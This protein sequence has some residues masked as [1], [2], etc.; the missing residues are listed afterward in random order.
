MGGG[1]PEPSPGHS[2]RGPGRNLAVV[3]PQ[4]HADV[5]PPPP[6]SIPPED[7]D[8][9]WRWWNHIGMALWAA[10]GGSRDGLNIFQTWSAKNPSYDAPGERSLVA[11]RWHHYFRSPPTRLGAGTLCYLFSTY[12]T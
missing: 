1:Y 4:R 8:G 9:T 11:A 6:S 5:V 12:W 7:L 2:T 3:E 10:S